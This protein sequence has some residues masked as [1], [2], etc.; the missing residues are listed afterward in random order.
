MRFFLHTTNRIRIVNGDQE[1]TGTPDEFQHHEPA[2]PGLPVLTNAPAVTRYQTP[3]W[4]YIED[5][6][7]V[8]HADLFD[9]LQYCDH[10][11][12]YTPVNPCIYADVTLSKTLLCASNPADTIPFTLAIRSGPEHADPVIPITAIWPIMLRQK[13]GL[14][15]DNIL[16]G[17]TNGE[18][19]GAYTYDSNLPLGEW[20]IDE[21]D[22]ALVPVGEVTYQVKLTAPARFTIY[23]NL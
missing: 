4:K 8:K 11:T 2:Y 15:M 17:V 16:I 23:R 20:Y 14:A 7:G 19:A 10:I 5:S 1:W 6:Q 18:F 22:F 13:N 21:Q 9:A 12:N 3:E